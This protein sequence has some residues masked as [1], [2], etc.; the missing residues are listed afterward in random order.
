METFDFWRNFIGNR[1]FLV[2]I[3]YIITEFAR[4]DTDGDS[5]FLHI[6][7]SLKWQKKIIR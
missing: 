1:S 6:F 5:W 4:S 3:Y 2:K 7:Y